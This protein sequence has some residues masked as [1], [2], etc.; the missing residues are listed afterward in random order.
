VKHPFAIED[1]L[2]N[3]ISFYHITAFLITLPFDLFYSQLVLTSFILHTLIHISKQKLHSSFTIKTLVLSSVFLVGVVGLFYSP[4][5]AQGIK[6][7]QRQLAIVLI[8]VFLSSS[9]IDLNKYKMKL[10]LLFSFSCVFTILYLY[11]DAIRIIL[12]NKIPL[13]SLFTKAFI[14][15]N[16]SIPV[17]IHATY[18]SMYAL[19]SAAILLYSFLKETN[20]SR[21]FIY[22]SSLLVLLAGLFQL[23]SKSVL[24]SAIIVA[25]SFPF[26][27]FKGTKRVSTIMLILFVATTAFF[28]IT[29]IDSFKRR[30]VEQFRADLTQSLG[31][32]EVPEPRIIRWRY[33]MQLIEQSPLFGYG[34]GSEKRVLNKVYFENKLYISYLHELNAHNQYLSFLLKTGIWGLLIFL[35]TLFAGFK[36]ALRNKD[37]L[38]WS[39]M[40]IISIVAFSENL[41]DVNKGIFF[42]AFFFTFFM[43][44]SKP[45]SWLH[46]SE[47]RQESVPANKPIH[48][49]TVNCHNHL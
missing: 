21:R 31:N 5:K 12:Y 13:S 23:A 6:D 20:N 47:K 4:D 7:L 16:F 46:R 32:T 44:A 9:G 1:T 26:I 2:E 36:T 29:N 49:A 35:F 22:L 11:A 38:F 25:L 48:A 42:Y 3:K 10:L 37:M 33:A 43:L 41:L 45:F 30:Y 17:N 18:L 19:L 34:S 15:H 8:P 27:M 40:I 14:N 39:F 28:T 24:I